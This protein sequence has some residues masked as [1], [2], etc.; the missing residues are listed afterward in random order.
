M[1]IGV[2]NE[3][4]LSSTLVFCH[5]CKDARSIPANLMDEHISEVHPPKA[6]SVGRRVSSAK[7]RYKKDFME[8]LAVPYIPTSEVSSNFWFKILLPIQE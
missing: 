5:L 1:Q 3:S 7:W 2:S 8:Q 6:V 4:C